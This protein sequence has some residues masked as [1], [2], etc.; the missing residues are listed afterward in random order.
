MA[1]DILALP[2]CEGERTLVACRSGAVIDA[3]QTT[4]I[5]V[6]PAVWVWE[7]TLVYEH[8]LL[9]L[10]HFHLQRWRNGVRAKFRHKFASEDL[11]VVLQGLQPRDLLN[12]RLPRLTRPFLD[13]HHL[14]RLFGIHHGRHVDHRALLLEFVSVLLCLVLERVLA[15]EE[16]EHA[17]L[18]TFATTLLEHGSS[19][20]EGLG[21]VRE[22]LLPLHGRDLRAHQFD[23]GGELLNLDRRGD[24]AIGH[25]LA[26][27]EQ[28]NA[29]FHGFVAVIHVTILRGQ[30]RSEV[31]NCVEALLLQRAAAVNENDQ[32]LLSDADFV[33]HASLGVALLVLEPIWIFRCGAHPFSSDG[34][35]HLTFSL[36]HA[37]TAS[38]RARRPRRPILQL[39]IPVAR[40]SVASFF[41][42]H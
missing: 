16:H 17:A 31:A 37:R 27:S 10:L 36:L 20:R 18:V 26:V 24:G 11:R 39:A 34:H 1:C 12:I 41:L 40:A 25:D 21:Q 33:P 32:V 30:V 3:V 2:V 6:C 5:F 13:L 42:R 23:V 28:D 7:T 35:Q 4:R 15:I 8:E 9:L 22:A 38:H 29:H 14:F 19:H